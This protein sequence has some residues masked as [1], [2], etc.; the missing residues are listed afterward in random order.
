MSNEEK[1]VTIDVSD[2]PL[3]KSLKEVPYEQLKVMGTLFVCSSVEW[4]NDKKKLLPKILEQL[5]LKKQDIQDLLS[6]LEQSKDQM[7]LSLPPMELFSFKIKEDYKW[8]TIWSF[9]VLSLINEEKYDSRIRV[10]LMKMATILKI[11]LEEFYN[12]EDD[13]AA[14]LDEK[15]QEI[16]KIT[17]EEKSKSAASTLGR[18]VLVGGASFLGGAA[19]LGI[20]ILAAPLIIPAILG[21]LGT[22]GIIGA[23]VG[24]ITAMGASILLLGGVPLVAGVFGATGAGLAGYQLVK[25]TSG[26]KHAEFHRINKLT[27]KVEFEDHPKFKSKSLIKYEFDVNEDLLKQKIQEKD[28]DL[29]KEGVFENSTLKEEEKE[30]L[31]QAPIIVPEKETKKIQEPEK[32]S[33]KEVHNVEEQKIVE[34][35]QES[36]EK[37][38]KIVKKLEVKKIEVPKQKPGM[39]LYISIS[40]FLK[41]DKKTESQYFWQIMRQQHDHGEMYCFDWEPDVLHSLGVV[42]HDFV[43]SNLSE[44]IR[45]SWLTALSG[46]LVPAIGGIMSAMAWP[47]LSL[48]VFSLV[49]NPWSV[50]LDRSVGAGK[51]LAE[52]LQTH[53]QGNR[54]V[55]LVGFS[56]GAKVIFECLQEL[57][58]KNMTGIVENVFLFGAPVPMKKK[59]FKEAR[60]VVAGRFVNGYSMKDWV[61]AFMYRASSLSYDV[62]G[63]QPCF[64]DLG[65]ENIDVSEVIEGHHEYALPLKMDQI[66]KSV[67]IHRSCE[68]LE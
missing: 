17:K 61:L 5:E 49:N 52:V 13:L 60:R 58:K 7:E 48:K 56:M 32:E 18:I 2:I 34:K 1:K 59:L 53:I 63:L 21:V 36:K 62:A 42:L 40:G 55:T 57:A 51:L 44:M 24:S 68:I 4:H 29:L 25:R 8:L 41:Y 66:L 28:S 20:G 6:L 45:G 9:L 37:T 22:V 19:L 35:I 30:I 12:A 10:S 43:G 38:D 54:P 39:N 47:L 3:I 50:A 64:E 46:M 31:E 16:Q 26:I 23:G 14:Q 65:I 11:D 33:E 27:E 15:L 67:D